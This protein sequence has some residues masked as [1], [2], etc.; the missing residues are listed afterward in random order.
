MG[1]P[2]RLE[3]FFVWKE[4]IGRFLPAYTPERPFQ[5]L[6]VMRARG[7]NVRFRKRRTFATGPDYDRNAAN[8]DIRLTMSI[9]DSDLE[10]Q[11]GI[12]FRHKKFPSLRIC[13]QSIRLHREPFDSAMDYSIE[14]LRIARARFSG[15]PI[16]RKG[17]SETYT[18][19][20]LI[21]HSIP[22]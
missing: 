21:P 6:P 7:V 13:C 2:C 4:R 16:S 5:F 18:P 17:V 11:A 10:P 1:N 15:V 12:R 14:A 9:R 20:T 19:S 3:N 8:S 22:A